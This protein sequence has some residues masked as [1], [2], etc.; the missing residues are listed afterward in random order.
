MKTAWIL[1]IVLSLL[2]VVLS[3]LLLTNSKFE[4]ALR[5]ALHGD[6]AIQQRK[7]RRQRKLE[8]YRLYADKDVTIAIIGDSHVNF[9]DWD[10]L[11]PGSGIVGFGVSGETTAGLRRS[12]PDIIQLN[13]QR[14]YIMIGCNDDVDDI[15]PDQTEENYISIVDSLL[16][17][18]I[19][20]VLFSTLFVTQE[21]P[22]ATAKNSRIERLNS[23][24]RK[25]AAQPDVDFIDLNGELT[26]GRFLLPEYAA[27]AIHLNAVGYRI[28]AKL[29][30][31]FE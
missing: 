6:S 19:R 1:V 24:L 28:W 4:R 12:L 18:D 7:L 14:C 13:P 29:I 30:R 16:A 25:L 22:D 10:R 5:R 8:M 17:S 11:L 23:V 2:V 21:Y 3:V 20:V 26:A 27:D 9:A 31:D 15:S